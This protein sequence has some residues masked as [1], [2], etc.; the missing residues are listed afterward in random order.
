MFASPIALR[1][2]FVIAL[3]PLTQA[4]NVLVRVETNTGV[5]GWGEASPFPTIHGET[6]DGVMAVGKFLAR[7]LLGADP[8]DMATVHQLMDCGIVGNAC[9]KSAFDLACHDLAARAEGVPLYAYLGG[10]SPREMFTDYTISLG[11]LEAMVAKARWIVAQGFPVIKIKLGGPPDQTAAVDPDVAR[12]RAIARA[13][14]PGVPLRL[15]ANQGW[16]TERA[17][18]ILNDLAGLPIQHCEAPIHRRQFLRLPDLRSRSPIPI[19]ADEACWDERDL[20]QLI[21]LKAV[22]KINVKLSKSGGLYRARKMLALAQE[23]GIPVQLGG[24]LESRLGFTAAAHLACADPGVKYFDFDTPL[25]Q[26]IDPIEGGMSYGEGGRVA[27]GPGNGLAA[28]PR[29]E[30]LRELKCIV[31]EG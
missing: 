25:M 16:T 14:G 19:M 24:F 10:S 30:Y 31:I 28:T 3:G 5:V 8:R 22:D 27:L 21:E 9:A 11:P 12:V 13:V 1:E 17:I 26:A 6:M 18:G 2:P 7:Q 20:Q 23:N 15:D 29:A 4:E